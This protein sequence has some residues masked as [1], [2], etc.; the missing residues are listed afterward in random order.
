MSFTIIE[1]DL[2]EDVPSTM[3]FWGYSEDVMR[4]APSVHNDVFADTFALWIFAAK[5]DR[6]FFRRWGLA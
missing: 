4:D 5:Y 6:G 3:N 1:R 2:V